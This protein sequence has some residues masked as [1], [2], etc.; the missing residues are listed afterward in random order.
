MTNGARKRQP[1]DALIGIGS[2]IAVMAVVASVVVAAKGTTPPILGVLIGLVLV[3]I[4][5]LQRRSA[6]R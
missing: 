1:G 4:G 5:Y 2:V 3:V 6:Q